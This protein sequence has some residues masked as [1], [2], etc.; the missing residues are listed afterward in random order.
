MLHCPSLTSVD[1]RCGRHP[2]WLPHSRADCVLLSLSTVI[3]VQCVTGC[4]AEFEAARYGREVGL[5]KPYTNLARSTEDSK[6]EFDRLA[7]AVQGLGGNIIV[8]DRECGIL[9]W[10]DLGYAFHVP[11]LLRTRF[12]QTPSLGSDKINLSTW[13]GFVHASA[14]VTEASSGTRTYVKAIARDETNNRVYCSDGHFESLVLGRQ[15][16]AS[17]GVPVES[18]ECPGVQRGKATAVS[19]REPDDSDRASSAD[20]YW[21]LYFGQYRD[22]P[23]LSAEEVFA[24]G[25]IHAVPAP[26]E[27]VWEACLDLVWQYDGVAQLSAEQRVVVFARSSSFPSASGAT[28]ETE[29]VDVVFAIA[30]RSNPA[31][32]TELAIGWL[33]PPHMT[34][35]KTE[36]AES[37]SG[38]LGR[39]QDRPGDRRECAADLSDRF[40]ME[41]AVQLSWREQLLNKLRAHHG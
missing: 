15:E 14:R 27:E 33:S 6:E 38:K 34:V 40:I 20:D 7:A 31:G 11:P 2:G 37:V 4:S 22:L 29:Y 16:K 21:H 30:L 25:T 39:D 13:H 26:V 10:V 12:E 35:K 5:R 8:A 18:I 3:F 9:S 36:R 41:L 17:A 1:K 28:S 24:G 19:G 23:C 32:G